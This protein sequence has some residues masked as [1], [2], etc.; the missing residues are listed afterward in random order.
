MKQRVLAVQAGFKGKLDNLGA[1]GPVGL[2]VRFYHTS[3][4]DFEKLLVAAP[5]V[6]QNL[7]NLH[8]Q[9]QPQH[10]RGAREVRLRQHLLRSSTKRA[11]SF[12]VVQRFGDRK[13][14]LH[15]EAVDNAA[16][17][18]IF[19]ELIRGAKREPR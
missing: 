12:Q 15:L 11:F 2:G 14:D 16:M 9:V 7:R 6:A 19:E 5:H 3:R 10:A 18:T 4:Y 1:A 8:H 17:G 13:V